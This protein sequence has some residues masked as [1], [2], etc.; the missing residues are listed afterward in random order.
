MD[1][2]GRKAK[3][4]AQEFERT[5][6]ELEATKWAAEQISKNH[7]SK[8]S[9]F[10]K[11]IVKYQETQELLAKDILTLQEADRNYKGNDYPDYAAAVQAISNKYNN[12]DDWG[13]L[14]TGAIVDLRAAFILGDGIKVVSR[15]EAK[16]EAKNEMAWVKD[17][18]EYNGL[19]SEMAQELAK[20]AE[21]AGKV[22]LRLFWDEPKEGKEPFRKRPGM[23]SVRFISWLQKKYT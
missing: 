6:L 23:G 13:C 11:R 21:I 1:M 15:T 5:K 20:E 9:E 8:V 19:D 16:E 4:Q 12:M 7:V 14:Q 10:E 22:A 3:A 17:F 18:L 2:F